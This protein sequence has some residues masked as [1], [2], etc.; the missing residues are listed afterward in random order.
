[1]VIGNHLITQPVMTVD[2]GRIIINLIFN[3][4]PNPKK[5]ETRN[6]FVARAVP[7]IMKEGKTQK[8]AVGKA[9]GMFTSAKKKK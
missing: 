1:M 5:G 4:M 3:Y 6:H 2:K 9:E 8:Q 7:I